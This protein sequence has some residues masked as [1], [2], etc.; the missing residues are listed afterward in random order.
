MVNRK[1]NAFNQTISSGLDF[2]SVVIMDTV[3][4]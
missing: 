2:P 1:I 3:S 4:M